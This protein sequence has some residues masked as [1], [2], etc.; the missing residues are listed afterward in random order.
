MMWMETGKNDVTV[1]LLPNGRIENFLL[2]Y[3]RPVKNKNI[4][5]PYK[6]K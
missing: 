5:K 6:K 3:K 4:V 2:L 1:T